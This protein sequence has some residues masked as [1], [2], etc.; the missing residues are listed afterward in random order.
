ML[1]RIHQIYF[2]TTAEL[3]NYASMCKKTH[4]SGAMPLAANAHWKKNLNP[5]MKCHSRPCQTH[6]WAHS[7]ARCK[8]SPGEKERLLPWLAE[9]IGG[10]YCLV[11]AHQ[12]QRARGKAVLDCRANKRN[13]FFWHVELGQAC[14]ETASG[15]LCAQLC[16]KP[17]TW[18]S[19]KTNCKIRVLKLF[20]F[21]NRK[22]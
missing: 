21:L 3:C 8:N 10:K 1:D 16:R 11:P 6:S 15:S 12:K 18:T 4:P 19:D 2:S 9:N 7:S 14:S 22:N 5:L 20:S 13:N 17:N